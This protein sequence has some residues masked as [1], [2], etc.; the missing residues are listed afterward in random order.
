M[1]VP[2]PE[3]TCFNCRDYRGYKPPKIGGLC[4]YRDIAQPHIIEIWV[5]TPEKGGCRNWH[6]KHE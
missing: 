3:R 5:R 6:E 2:Y 1:T 4:L